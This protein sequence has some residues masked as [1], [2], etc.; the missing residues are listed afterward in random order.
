MSNEGCTEIIQSTPPLPPR[1]LS[2]SSSS[3][4]TRPPLPPKMRDIDANLLEAGV[5]F[6]PP[7]HR[8]TNDD[9]YVKEGDISDGGANS[10]HSSSSSDEDE[11]EE[12]SSQHQSLS[13][14]PV[15]SASPP[16][17]TPAATTTKC[18][19]SR[20]ASRSRL[21]AEARQYADAIGEVRD[22]AICCMLFALRKQKRASKL[23]K[24]TTI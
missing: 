17:R 18:P 19:M 2:C 6:S 16:A 20:T 5:T 8:H 14:D 22:D 4:K 24:C 3:S 11:D 15:S 13:G 12:A 23:I 21:L 10:P 1:S 9:N 7:R